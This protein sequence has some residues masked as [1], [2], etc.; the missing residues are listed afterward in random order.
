M[1]TWGLHIRIAEVLINKE[2]MDLDKKSFLVGNIAADA[3]KPN[4]DRSAFDS[5]PEISHWKDH[6]KR[7]RPDFF[8]KAHLSEFYGDQK[9][10]SFFLGYYVHLMTDL[11]WE[12]FFE[13]MKEINPLYKKVENDKDYI[14]VIKKDW[15]DLDH[16][17]FLQNQESV[18]WTIF[19]HI[20]RFPDYLDYFEQGQIYEKICYIKDF[21][22]SPPSDF[23]RP[24]KHLQMEDMNAFV[25]N[26]VSGIA[27]DLNEKLQR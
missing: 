19:Q 2:Q 13:H 21:Y 7:I 6:K 1:A 11:W 23:N 16:L 9:K 10:R 3:G 12:A 27:E 8:Y 18:F 22:M 5:P 15:Y 20:D 17:Y 24:Y 4:A 25:D 14:W 26:V